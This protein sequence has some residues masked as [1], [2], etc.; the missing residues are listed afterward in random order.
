MGAAVTPLSACLS[1]ITDLFWT[2]E[3]HTQCLPLDMIILAHKGKHIVVVLFD[4]LTDK[5][6]L[7]M[8]CFG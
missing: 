4:M 3:V 8:C 7:D 5:I 2:D 1:L 6:P